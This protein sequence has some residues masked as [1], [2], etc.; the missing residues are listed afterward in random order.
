MKVQRSSTRPFERSD[1][2]NGSQMHLHGRWLVLVRSAWVLLVL[3]TVGLFVA[4][5][6]VYFALFHTLC[7]V[8]TQC[9]F[10]ENTVGPPS[11]QG[12]WSLP[13]KERNA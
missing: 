8:A 11:H 1:V 4:S 6:P 7:S 2:R 9:F 3:F 13:L 12:R 5:L 10:G